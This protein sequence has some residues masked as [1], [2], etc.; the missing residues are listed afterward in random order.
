MVK[1]GQRGK[2]LDLMHC[3]LFHLVRSDL[4]RTVVDDLYFHFLSV[5]ILLLLCGAFAR[6][7]CMSD[8]SDYECKIR[9]KLRSLFALHRKISENDEKA[10][11]S[12]TAQIDCVENGRSVDVD[13]LEMLVEGEFHAIGQFHLILLLAHLQFLDRLSGIVE[14]QVAS[15]GVGDQLRRHRTVLAVDLCQIAPFV[16]LEFGA[17][18]Q[19]DVIALA[20]S[21]LLLGQHH[22]LVAE[23]ARD[24]GL[25]LGG[26]H[27]DGDGLVVV[28]MGRNSGGDD[29]ADGDHQKSHCSF[30]KLQIYCFI[31]PIYGSCRDTIHCFGRL[32]VAM[33]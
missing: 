8:V 19:H 9:N 22:L 29:A 11:F 4:Y 26:K 15:D 21:R 31:I 17:I 24:H 14:A 25:G 27:G 33:V 6:C 20:G 7:L 23:M 28:H 2:V 18:A 3:R 32:R 30:H 1:E 12:S 13:Q 16:K 5:L 10:H